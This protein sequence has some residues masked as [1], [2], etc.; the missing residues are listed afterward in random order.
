MSKL[1][2]ELLTKKWRFPLL[3]LTERLASYQERT[4]ALVEW[5]ARKG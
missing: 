2:W 1:K 5:I 4:D 3:W